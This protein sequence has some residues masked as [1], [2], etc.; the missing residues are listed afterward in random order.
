[1]ATT[2]AYKVRDQSGK[3]IEGELDAEDGE[4]GQDPAERVVDRGNGCQ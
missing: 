4:V 1:M 3:L 2:F